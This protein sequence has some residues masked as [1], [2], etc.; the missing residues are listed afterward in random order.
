MNELIHHF[1]ALPPVLQ[2]LVVACGLFLAA[3]LFLP[4]E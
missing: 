3:S 1:D 4:T 2:A